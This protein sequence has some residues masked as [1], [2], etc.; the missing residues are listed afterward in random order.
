MKM[1]Y[2]PNI[3]TALKLAQSIKGEKASLTIIPD[4]VSVVVRN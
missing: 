1:I 2:A 4:G 3:E